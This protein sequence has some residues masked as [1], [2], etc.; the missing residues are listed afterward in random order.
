MD[1]PIVN[2]NDRFIDLHLHLDGAVTPLIARRLGEMQ[3]M[4]LPEDELLEKQLCVPPEC[5][6]LND[7]LRCFELPLTLL[8]TREALA[9][10]TKLVCKSLAEQG[11]V[12]AEIRFAPQLHCQRG[13]SQE[14]AVRAVLDG[15]ESC[16]FDAGLILCCMRGRGN[17]KEN[18]ETLA[19]TAK[20][21]SA[22][23]GA[24]A[25]DLAGAEALF[26]TRNYR[27]LFENAADKGIPFTI[28]AG[29]A[30]GADSIREAV[31]FGASRIGHGVRCF[32]DGALAELVREKGIPLEMCLTSNRQT[33]A[34][35][36]M[37]EHPFM[38][39]FSQ[40]LKVTLNTDDPA[41]ERTDIAA[42][43]RY[44]E[45]LFG[46]DGK[47]KRQLLEN[48]VEAAFAGERVKARV[49]AELGL[50]AGGAVDG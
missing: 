1:R 41:I 49:R 15:L 42:E 7:F 19:L 46:I 11:V 21:L 17:E 13:M 5:L 50:A 18:A 31:N 34:V 48:A 26:P 29:E 6:S 3:G 47:Q 44:A 35:E 16:P 23:G 39:Y 40:G 32:E 28:H 4:A 36:N 30:D 37:A 12:Y 22:E 43:Y 10:C 27:E 45:E 38:R 20:Y 8:Q 14:D 24:A 33:H 9:E 25:M 2:R